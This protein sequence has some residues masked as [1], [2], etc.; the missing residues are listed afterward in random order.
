VRAPPERSTANASPASGHSGRSAE[1]RVPRAPGVITADAV[2]TIA[3]FKSR[4]GVGLGSARPGDRASRSAT[5]VAGALCWGRTSSTSSSNPR[6][7]NSG[8]PTLARACMPRVASPSTSGRAPRGTRPLANHAFTTDGSGMT[9]N[10]TK[11]DDHGGAV[12]TE[13]REAQKSLDFEKADVRERFIRG[14]EYAK[15]PVSRRV[16]DLILA[17]DVL[18][19]TQGDRDGIVSI[20]DPST[21]DLMRV[22]GCS[23]RTVYYA[24]DDVDRRD[25]QWPDG[26]P[27]L[28]VGTKSNRARGRRD[29]LTVHWDRI[30]EDSRPSPAGLPAHSERNC[31]PQIAGLQNGP[32]AGVQTCNFAGLQPPSFSSLDPSLSKDPLTV[33]RKEEK[34]GSAMQLGPSQPSDAERLYD[35]YPLKAARGAAIKAIEKALRKASFDVLFKAVTSFAD[36][37]KAQSQFCPYAAKWFDE[38][39]WADDPRLWEV[40]PRHQSG[41]SR[42][43]R[44]QPYQDFLNRDQP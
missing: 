39:R 27:Y 4:A 16:Q 29:L 28:T 9:V 26:C 24:L 33:R 41:S 34:D 3:E 6:P 40:K 42:A 38:E 43:D 18:A 31:K 11:H 19:L 2:Y 15:R 7:M 21:A 17:A 32:I 12:T 13:A 30:V 20:V 22:M 37:A 35:A 10:K 8:L 23:E 36:S 14:L 44:Q 5:R 25:E 1:K